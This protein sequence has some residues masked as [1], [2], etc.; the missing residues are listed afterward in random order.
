MISGN[1]FSRSVCLLAFGNLGASAITS[2]NSI[3]DKFENERFCISSDEAGKEWILANTPDEKLASLCFH[4]PENFALNSLGLNLSG[5][6][7]YSEFGKERFI[8]LTTFKWHLIGDSL[9][10]HRDSPGVLFTDLDVIW[11]QSPLEQEL[12]GSD[13]RIFVQ[14]DTPKNHQ[15]IHLCSGVMYFPNNSYSIELLSKLFSEQFNANANGNLIP[16]EP[17]LN[18]WFLDSNQDSTK[19]SVLDREKFIIGHRYFYFLLERRAR[20]QKAV[21]FHLNYVVGEDRKNR[22]A[23]AL[24]SRKVGSFAWIFYASIDFFEVVLRRLTAR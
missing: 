6:E 19:L 17:I 7:K 9:K 5:S 20:R 4:D 22:R 11:F 15:F 16:D 12:S 21:C 14:D 24:L 23:K 8:K 3:Y 13:S 1:S 18:R 10:I 2:L